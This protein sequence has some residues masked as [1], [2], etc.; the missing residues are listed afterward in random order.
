MQATW[1]AFALG[2][3][4]ALALELAAVPPLRL[5]A[6]SSDSA[7]LQ[8]ALTWFRIAALG[9]PFML[10]I[11]AAQGWLRAFQDTRTGLV[12]LVA[13]NLASVRSRSR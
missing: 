3:L 12:V 4:C 1:L 7:S 13:S 9:A 8:E 2:G 11:A 6:G 10:V 5:I